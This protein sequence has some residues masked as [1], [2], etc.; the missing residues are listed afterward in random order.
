MLR[1]AGL[2]DASLAKAGP[3]DLVLAARGRDPEAAIR[4]GQAALE[5]RKAPSGAAQELSVRTVRSAARRLPGANVALVSVPGPH[6][7]WA[8]WDALEQGLHVF[9]FSNNVAVEDEI[10]LKDEALRR[11]LLFM[12][13]D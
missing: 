2:F 7:P 10:A 3:D 5:E 11:G 13:P 6:A 1:E 4:A 8:C 9:C 12:G